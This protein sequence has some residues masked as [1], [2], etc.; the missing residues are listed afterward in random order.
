VSEEYRVGG[1]RK[2]E[3]LSE[4]IPRIIFI[5]VAVWVAWM[6]VSSYVAYIRR[7]QE[8]IGQ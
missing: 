7:I 8:I 4:W 1:L 2:M 6:A 3:M 5:S